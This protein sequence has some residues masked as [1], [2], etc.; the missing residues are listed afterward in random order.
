ML[1]VE[2]LIIVI[3][4]LSIGYGINRLDNHWPDKDE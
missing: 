4:F 1:M 3:A 2:E